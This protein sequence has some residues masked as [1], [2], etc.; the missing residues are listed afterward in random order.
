VA[1]IGACYEIGEKMKTLNWM[2]SLY[3]LQ[4]HVVTPTTTPEFPQ[5]VDLRQWCSPIEDQGQIGSCTANA[6]V[7][8]LEWLENKNKDTNFVRLSRLFV[9]YN[10]RN[11]EGSTTTDSG[12]F[13]HDGINS[14]GQ[15]GICEE[16][17]WPYDEA[18]FTVKPSDTAYTEALQRR[19]H[20][21]SRISGKEQMLACLTEGY[22]FVFGV[23]V[24]ESTF[25]TEVPGGMVAM[26]TG[27]EKDLGGHAMC[28]VG[29]DMEK[30]LFIVRNSWGEEWGDKGY[31]YFPFEYLVY[32]ADDCWTVRNTYTDN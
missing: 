5:H 16:P 28:C 3:H 20:T 2:R 25:C 22:P 9:Y 1:G 32:F 23:Q 7:S 18:K 26:I 4:E 6:I 27:D 31:C 30:E 14:I 13:I 21:Y 17:I 19:Y 10:E 24:E 29:Y 12:A 8:M 15:L 11:M